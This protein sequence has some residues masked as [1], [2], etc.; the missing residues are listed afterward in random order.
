MISIKI[1]QQKTLN[2]KYF[3]KPPWMGSRRVM[4]QDPASPG[5]L[6]SGTVPSSEAVILMIP[7]LDL[8]VYRVFLI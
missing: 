2:E 6:P 1:N 3:V 8:C 5:F 4:I 7:A